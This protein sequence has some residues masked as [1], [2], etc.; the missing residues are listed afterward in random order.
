[1]VAGHPPRLAPSAQ[2]RK[3]YSCW[4]MFTVDSAAVAVCTSFV[5]SQR[6]FYSRPTIRPDQFNLAMPQ[7]RPKMVQT[8]EK[9]RSYAPHR[10]LDGGPVEAAT[11]VTCLDI[12][13]TAS[14]CSLVVRFGLSNNKGPKRP[15]ILER[16]ILGSCQ[17]SVARD[18]A[19]DGKQRGKQLRKPVLLCSGVS[20]H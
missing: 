10:N 12:M 19:S 17:R 14:C 16:V 5:G 11:N 9:D 7:K 13:T 4:P 18:G 2:V 6:W 3:I 20:R 15:V 1:M 8:R